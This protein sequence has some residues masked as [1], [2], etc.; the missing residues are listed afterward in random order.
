MPTGSYA[1]LGGS[2]FQEINTT[3]SDKRPKELNERFLKVT[4]ISFSLYFCSDSRKWVHLN[5]ES[6]T[7]C[8]K[9]IRGRG[10]GIMRINIRNILKEILNYVTR[11]IS[12]SYF[13]H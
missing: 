7:L 8:V 13:K 6:W 1:N 9:V 11:S 3:K 12:V 2:C 4:G 5:W 10:S